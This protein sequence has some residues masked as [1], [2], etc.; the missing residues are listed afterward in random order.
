MTVINQRYETVKLLGEGGFGSVYSVKDTFEHDK[1]LALKKIKTGIISKKAVNVFKLEFK[2]LTSLIHPN[3]VKVH[4]FDIDKDT[5]ELFFTMEHIKGKSLNKSLKESFSWE[6]VENNLIQSS[7]ALSY[8]HSKEIIHYDI[9]PDN[10]FIDDYGRLKLMDFGFAGSKNTTEVR[11]TMQFI[12]P[13]LILKKEITNQ[14][15][16]FSLG[17]TFY[18]SIT[19]KLPFKGKDKQEII[20]NSIRGNFIPLKKLKPDTPEKLIRVIN[21]LMDPDPKKRYDNAD[22]I[23]LDLV[24]DPK[25][26]SSVLFLFTGQG[27]RS[28]IS[29]GKLIGRTEELKVLMS[30]SAKVF[31]E[32]V[33]FDNKPFFLI[34]R[35]GNGKSSILREYKYKIQLNE[36][37]DYFN[38]NF[39]RGDETKYQ[40]FEIIIVEMFRVYELKHDDYPELSFIFE[41][42][43]EI[44]DFDDSSQARVQKIREI[45]AIT[46]FFADLSKQYK[47]VLEVK[48]FGNA[49]SSSINLFENLTRIMRKYPENA[50]SFTI[51][52]TVQT[53]NLKSYHKI[54]IK[55]LKPNIHQLDINPLKVD[56]TRE[57]VQNLLLYSDYNKFPEELLS[58]VHRFTGGVP[59][60][61]N[62]LFIY[63]FSNNYLSRSKSKWV[64]NPAFMTELSL[65]LRDI[66]YKNFKKFSNIEQAI[67]KEL[68]ILE[69]PTP[70]KYMNIVSKVSMVDKKIL[71]KFLHKLSD[72][73][74]IE[75][76]KYHDGFRYYITKKL[77]LDS[78]VKDF[79][80]EQYARWNNKT[81][82][83][84]EKEYGINN[85]TIYALADYYF[86]SPQKDKAKEMLQLAISKSSEENNLEFAVTNLKRYLAIETEPKSK[87]NIFISIIQNLSILGDYNKVL[88]Q[89]VKF[90]G[91]GHTLTLI[92]K[93][94]ITLVKFDSSFKAGRY[95]Y[96]DETRS[97]LFDFKL[98]GKIPKEVRASY[99][100]WLGDFHKNDGNL[101]KSLKFYK[102]AFNYHKSAKRELLKSKVMLKIAKVL[103]LKGEI[104]L[105]RDQ[106]F[107]VLDIFKKYNEIDLI[108]ETYYTLGEYYRQINNFENSLSSFNDCNILAKEQ[109]NIVHEV[110]SSHKLAEFKIESLQYKDALSLINCGV[111]KP[112]D[113]NIVD[114]TGDIYYYRSILN[115]QLGKLED[116]GDD[117]NKCINVRN[118]LKRK[119]KLGEAYIQKGKIFVRQCKFVEA[120]NVMEI[121]N[122]FI[123][124][125]NKKFMIK[126]QILESLILIGGN[127]SKKALSILTK[128]IKLIDK[129]GNL[130]ERISVNILLAI[131]YD[132][133]GDFNNTL[134]TIGRTYALY[135]QNKELLVANRLLNLKL[136]SFYNKAKA[137][138]GAHEDGIREMSGIIQMIGNY[139]IPFYKATV[140]YN[141]GNIYYDTNETYRAVACYKVAVRE[142]EK[143]SPNYPELKRINEIIKKE[144]G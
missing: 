85:E 93:L 38:A 40:A 143:L 41:N 57:Y 94:N 11:G 12:A 68:K 80:K 126:Y 88:D 60:Y 25:K 105:L 90:E 1:L 86:R 53:E 133:L 67:I 82:S 121:L 123:T 104:K 64:I 32:Q 22:E 29:S 91:E 108:L 7:R 43:S 116:A 59:F 134:G 21:K 69:R 46:D 14:I 54:T 44:E 111:E 9:K 58:F 13:E 6:K 50:M 42:K 142:Y 97:W 79:S 66:T 107:E 98:K 113:I 39:V 70:F 127:K 100:T 48:D 119:G 10:I 76:I 26:R 74:V 139:K 16:F 75:K 87:I 81:A 122:D 120:K 109:N 132:K 130:P 36:N 63:L 95:N 8:I 33:F 47:F 18:Y 23:I 35:Y 115:Y 3:L 71:I 45:E 102:K 99:L 28:Y 128:L 15:D 89:I 55:R 30:N 136:M 84:L 19:G 65:G 138:A 77:F 2:F 110:K 37:I 118:L 125:E 56:E 78:V 141:L 61:I 72:S 34:G 52:T 73:E 131:V 101:N 62:E 92:N 4:D 51:V 129:I 140:N 124:K 27:I 24:D 103:I 117:I 83:M 17:V 112:E 5:D 135:I 144:E 31:Q 49:N 106:I 137:Y 114:L 96:L 20:G